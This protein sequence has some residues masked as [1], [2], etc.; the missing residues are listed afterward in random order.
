MKT[1]RV[2]EKSIVALLTI[3]MVFTQPA[4][5]DSSAHT[6]FVPR[7]MAY[8]PIYE[9]ALTF[10]EY[11]HMG[12]Q[13]LLLSVKPMYTQTVGSSLKKYFNINHVSD[14]N[15]RENGSGNI[16]SLWFQVISAPDTYYS[17][18]VSFRPI[19]QTYG[20][21]FYL[22]WMLPADF[23][24]TVNTAF[25]KRKNNMH[26]RET[27]I[28]ADAFGQLPGFTT[29]SEAFTNPTMTYGK[30]NGSQ[31]KSGVDDLQI[32]LL[33]NFRL[34]DESL[35]LVAY[36]LAGA[37]TGHGS[38]AVSLFEPIVG[39]KHAQAGL[40]FNAEKSWNFDRCNR[41][42]LYGELKWRYGFKA[43]ETRSFDMTPNGQW[44]RYLLFT[45]PTA[46]ANPFFAINN[47]TFKA[48]VTPRNSVDL[49]LAAHADH[50]N[51]CFELGY[52]FW[53]RQAEKVTPFITLPEVGVADLVG[54]AQLANTTP[55]TVTTAS[56]ATISEGVYPNE[57][58]M[59]RDAVYTLVAADNID[60]KSGTQ[61]TS[62]ANAVFG[63]FGYQC[64]RCTVGVNVS[65][66]GAANS[67]TASIVSVWA[68]IDIR[69]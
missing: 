32:K 21:M 10:D 45:T 50:N 2:F 62:L 35:L 37:P 1:I 67:N 58:Q 55:V 31:S 7:Q 14:M 66:E 25:V 6:I 12:D 60:T 22:A 63:S 34:C 46:D 33:K 61:A 65:Y 51:F 53:Y 68:N 16:D 26:I 23:A 64:E 3:T 57:F 5:T 4:R 49:L 47:L 17:S 41:F 20:T 69:F 30:I 44:S 39:S 54:I 43:K 27:D 40:G 38:K 18:T 9:Q 19:Q 11:A 36:A 15:V 56:N 59:P 8:N 24:L 29:V 28:P 42:A 48:N 52:N 13:F